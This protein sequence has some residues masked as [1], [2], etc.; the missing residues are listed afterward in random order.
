MT[1]NI[2]EFDI[3]KFDGILARGLSHGLGTRGESVCIEAAICET[4]GV[5]HGDDPGCV[6]QAVRAYKIKLNDSRW[7][8]PKERSKGLRDLGIAQLGSLGSIDSKEFSRRLAEK[9][10]R[11]LIPV[12]FRDLFPNNKK[13]LAV[14]DRC[15]KEGTKDAA[16]A[17]ANAADA[18]ADADKYLNL[19]AKLALEV[20]REMQSPGV[21][22]L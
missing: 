20:L 8:S 13:L 7:S 10:I 5:E 9:T 16:Y 15:E 6:D 12:L 4:L 2:K 1:F 19:S 11:V 21:A 22:L 18:A 3:E 17:A 14:A